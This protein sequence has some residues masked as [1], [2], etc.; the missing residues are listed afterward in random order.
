MLIIWVSK[1]IVV[2]VSL[3]PCFTLMNLFTTKIKLKIVLTRLKII[4]FKNIIQSL[5]FPQQRQ[6]I[7]LQGLKKKKFL[8]LL[9]H[10]IWLVNDT[11]VV[12]GMSNYYLLKCQRQPINHF[13][14]SNSV[15]VGYCLNIFSAPTLHSNVIHMYSV[16]KMNCGAKSQN[17]C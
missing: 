12:I 1:R 15:D 9:F 17:Q 16:F 7:P 13:C 11:R 2:S 8:G 14:S 4:R 6:K 3:L 5:V 10:L